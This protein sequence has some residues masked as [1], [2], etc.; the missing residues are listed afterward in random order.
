MEVGKGRARCLN[1]Y[2]P[3]SALTGSGPMG[4]NKEIFSFLFC[5]KEIK[6]TKRK[7]KKKNVR[8]KDGVMNA[9]KS[10]TVF[11]LAC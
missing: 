9:H 3:P 6:S 5:K 10:C 2:P 8:G 7:Q 11:D 1:S 4:C